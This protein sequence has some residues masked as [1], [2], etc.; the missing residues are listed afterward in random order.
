MNC[1]NCLILEGKINPPC[2][3]VYKNDNIAVCHNL[4]H[5]IPGYLLLFPIRHVESYHE[6]TFDEAADLSLV[7]RKVV[8]LLSEIEGVE[9]V[10]IN[11]FGE[12]TRHL[13]FHL[14]PRY[15][16]MLDNSDILQNGKID[17]IQIFDKLRKEMYVGR[18]KMETSEILN[19]TR[20]IREEL[21]GVKS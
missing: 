19:V 21:Y 3:I 9:R 17:A 11:S 8:A 14:F 20:H 13:H 12:E 6:L 4:E 10:Y 1:L 2:G 7:M 16:W 15:K 18:S 5:L